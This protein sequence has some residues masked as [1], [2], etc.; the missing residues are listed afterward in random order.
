MPSVDANRACNAP[1]CRRAGASAARGTLV[2]T[3]YG[4]VRA[5]YRVGT[6]VVPGS[7]SV[8]Q[9]APDSTVGSST[10][11][12]RGADRIIAGLGDGAGRG[13]SAQLKSGRGRGGGCG[14]PSGGSG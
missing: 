2:A 5:W 9:P 11:A 12:R 4:P 13:G 8:T 7:P 1:S 6:S 3:R 10:T 14:P